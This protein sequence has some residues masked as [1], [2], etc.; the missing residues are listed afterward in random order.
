MTGILTQGLGLQFLRLAGLAGD[1]QMRRDDFIHNGRWFDSQGTYL[2]WGDLSRIDLL[3]IRARLLEVPAQFI[4]IDEMT[5][6]KLMYQTGPDGLRRERKHSLQELYEHA[7]FVVTPRRIAMRARVE[8]EGKSAAS[9]L[10]LWY[11]ENIP[12]GAAAEEYYVLASDVFQAL[13]RSREP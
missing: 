6:S 4:V 13:L 5:A 11:R 8:S 10:P 3:V 2:G 12:T 7:I 9:V 1:G